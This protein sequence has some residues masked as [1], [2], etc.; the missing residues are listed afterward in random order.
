MTIR[1]S[2]QT[3]FISADSVKLTS[4]DLPKLPPELVGVFNTDD[5]FRVYVNGIFIEH[6]KYNYEEIGT[7]IHFTFSTGS[8]SEGGTYPDDLVATSTDLGYIISSSD[9]VGITGKFIEL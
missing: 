2:K 1:G 4:V 6:A 5:W 9:E 7:E 3:S 8:L